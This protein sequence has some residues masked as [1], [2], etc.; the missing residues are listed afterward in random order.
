MN[1]TKKFLKVK[2]HAVSGESFNLVYDEA[3]GWLETSPRPDKIER[4]YESQDYISHTDAKRNWFE[5]IYQLVRSKAI[6]QKL[7]LID[8]QA[9]DKGNLLDFGCGTGDFLNKAQDAG[10]NITGIE[11]NDKARVIANEKTNNAVFPFDKIKDLDDKNYDVIT[12]WHVL[13]HLDQPD[14]WLLQFKQLLKKNGT[15]ILAVPNYESFD[16]SYYGSF[17]AAYDVPRHLWHF[18]K[19]AMHRLASKNDMKVD[20]VFPMIFDAYYVSLLSEKYKSGWMNIFNA[21]FVATRSNIKAAR[22][23]EYSS[24]IYVLKHQ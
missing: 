14:K 3:M 20:A 16:A 10:W 19:S 12:L 24:L 23:G 13:E 2:D 15:L 7:K 5:R 6:K 8:K 1:S 9:P 17:W 11:P 18:S 21:L 22:N 4:Y